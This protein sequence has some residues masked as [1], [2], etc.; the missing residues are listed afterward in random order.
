MPSRR[1]RPRSRGAFFYLLTCLAVATAGPAVLR[2]APVVASASAAAYDTLVVRAAPV[3]DPLAAAATAT[4]TL[5]EL[6]PDRPAPELADVLEE[7]AGL[8]VRRYGGLGA[9]VLPSVRG[10]SAGQVAVLVDGLPLADAQ[11]GVIDLS[12]LS[13]DR[14]A[15]VEIYRGFVPARFG[16]SGG[17]GAVNLVTRR[18]A[19][20]LPVRWLQWAGSHGEAGLRLEG[21]RGGVRAVLHGRR[22]DNRFGFRNHNQTFAAPDDDFDDRRGNAWLREG[23]ALLSGEG[24]LGGWRARA[25][26]GAH[27]RDAGRPGPVGGYESPH[28]DLR[29]DRRDLRVTLASPRDALT[30]D[31]DLRR[32]DERL[33]DERGEVGWD[34]P[35][36][37]ESRVE[38]LGGRAAWRFGVAPGRGFVLDGRLGLERRRQRFDWRH[39]D[40]VDPRRTRDVVGAFAALSLASDRTG[41]SLSPALRWRRH[42]DDFPAVPAWPGLPE[43]PLSEPNVHEQLSPMVEL[44]WDARPGVLRWELHWARSQRAPSWVELFGQRGGVDGNRELTPERIESADATVHWRPVDACRLRLAGFVSRIDDAIVWTPNSQYTSRADNHGRM[45]TRGVEAELRLEAGS[46]GRLWGSLTVQDTE[47][48][49]EDP[50]YAGKDLPYLPALEA[51]LGWEADRGPWTAGL[52]WRHASSSYRDRYNTPMDRIPGRSRLDVSLSRVW[53][54]VHPVGRGEAELACSLFNLFDDDTYDVEG[55]PLPGRSVRVSFVMH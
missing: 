36:V 28:A 17:A 23:G 24:A 43:T 25:S 11:D 47:D 21:A 40:L 46:A 12:T 2:A 54:G 41:L 4:A 30:L 13:L 35:G 29:I 51:A 26:V 19:N 53:T 14:F 39:E 32:E 15:R 20:A 6:D 45:R 3:A 48:R 38:H 8:Q 33:R 44:A 49:G 16:G 18:D 5:V 34:P 7:V 27:R 31:F 42:E 55:Y 1:K 9:P 22:A 50:I 10:S 37:T 52:R